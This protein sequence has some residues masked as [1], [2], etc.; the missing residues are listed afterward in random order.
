MSAGR[1]G[2]A[3]PGAGPPA[4]EL[5]SCWASRRCGAGGHRTAGGAEDSAEVGV[6]EGTGEATAWRQG[7]ARHSGRGT[8]RPPGDPA[9]GRPRPLLPPPGVGG[10]GGLRGHRPGRRAAGRPGSRRGPSAGDEHRCATSVRGLRPRRGPCRR[11]PRTYH[12]PAARGPDP[13]A[14]WETRGG[15]LG[16]R[17]P[18][19]Q[20]A[21]AW[22]PED[23]GRK[24]LRA[25]AAGTSPNI[26]PRAP[27]H[28]PP[29]GRDVAG[30]HGSGGGAG[31]RWPRT[32]SRTG[33]R[34]GPSAPST[35][36][37]QLRLRAPGQKPEDPPGRRLRPV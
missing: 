2:P 20:G 34:R 32:G 27:L 3:R 25:A 10:A 5:H 31:G 22:D 28:A 1:V 16:G 15:R 19:F 14:V 11:G 13:G 36:G 37:L 6:P 29:S 4:S 33:A 12:S 18:A 23:L 8:T 9:H 17:R 21:A 30:R 7:R 35:S 24:H 26:E